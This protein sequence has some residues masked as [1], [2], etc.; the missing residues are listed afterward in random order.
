MIPKQ[1]NIVKSQ[2]FLHGGEFANLV[3]RLRVGHVNDADVVACW[4]VEIVSAPGELLLL[5]P[6]AV[7]VQTF[8]DRIRRVLDIYG[9]NG[10]PKGLGQIRLLAV[11]AHPG[12]V[13][14]GGGIGF[15]YR[16][17]VR[18]VRQ[19]EDPQTIIVVVDVQVIAVER[20][21]SIATGLDLVV[22]GD[23][24]WVMRVRDVKG[25]QAGEVLSFAQVETVSRTILAVV[26]HVQDIVF[27]HRAK[28]IDPVFML[29][30][31]FEGIDTC[32]GDVGRI[33]GVHQNEAGGLLGGVV[34][35]PPLRGHNGDIT[36]DAD[37]FREL[38]HLQSL[39]LFRFPKIGA[40]QGGIS[41][42]GDIDHRETDGPGAV[43][44]AA[45]LRRQRVPQARS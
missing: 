39:L 16:G 12:V 1:A 33:G 44:S 7:P 22:A 40:Q 11:I 2:G 35:G 42:I 14:F 9:V 41:R 26:G 25:Q 13:A 5:V 31:G 6:F 36:L 8:L 37:E 4:H 27:R 15:A 20:Q 32:P 21:V 10:S 3:W 23:E 30:G 29:A 18:W 19:A 43:I 17:G 28:Q 38:A 45:T 24:L 34:V